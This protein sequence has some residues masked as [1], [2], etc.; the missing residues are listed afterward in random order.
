M[1]KNVGTELYSFT[2]VSGQMKKR[3]SKR[4]IYLLLLYIILREIDQI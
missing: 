2:S 4:S 3:T 1:A